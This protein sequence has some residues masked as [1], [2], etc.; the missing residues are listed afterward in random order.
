MSELADKERTSRPT[1]SSHV[2]RLEAEGWVQRQAPQA[3]DRRRVGLA[4]TP[5]GAKALDARAPAPHRLAGR[6]ADPA[7]AG[8]ARPDRRGAGAAGPDR[9]GPVMNKPVTES[10]KV[11]EEIVLDD[12]PA[13]TPMSRFAPMIIGFALLMQTLDATV[14][15]NA[16]AHHGPV[17]A[18]RPADAEPGQSPPTY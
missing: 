5:A 14:I 10:P 3:D 4:I 18:R 13:L 15:S 1:M 6:P 8:T 11:L 17:A 12:E 9:G 7:D 16:P 2:K